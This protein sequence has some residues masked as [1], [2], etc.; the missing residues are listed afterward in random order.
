MRWGSDIRFI[1]V[2]EREIRLLL[3]WRGLEKKVLVVSC[4]FLV[5]EKRRPTRKGKMKLLVVSF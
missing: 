3:I 5:S 1:V 4:W 2:R